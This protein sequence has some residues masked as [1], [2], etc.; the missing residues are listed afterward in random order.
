MPG[1]LHVPQDPGQGN[2]AVAPDSRAES[3]IA[4][5]NPAEAIAAALEDIRCRLDEA[6]ESY[7][8]LAWERAQEAEK[9]KT[10]QRELGDAIAR[11]EAAENSAALLRRE[12]AD[13]IDAIARARSALGW[14]AA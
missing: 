3:T 1:P 9:A 11:A 5:V 7:R 12:N 14:E 2:G 4:R 13:L 10:A 8:E 6:D